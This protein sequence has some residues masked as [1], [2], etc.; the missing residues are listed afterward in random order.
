[1]S[2]Q[3]WVEKVGLS[4]ELLAAEAASAPEV[5]EIAK[6]LEQGVVDSQL[7]ADLSEDFGQ[8]FGRIPPDLAEE[9]ELL[10]LARSGQFEGLLHDAAAALRARL[11]EDAG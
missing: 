7:G 9:S 6:L 10:S 3:L 8:L 5:D 1:M 2:D 11:A 4:T